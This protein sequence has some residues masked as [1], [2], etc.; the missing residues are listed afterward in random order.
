MYFKKLIILFFPI[1]LLSNDNLNVFDYYHES[2]CSVL[3]NTSNSIDDY[4]IEDN[5]ST[6]ST[7]YAEFSTL[8]AKES[9]SKLEKDIRFH[10]RLNLPKI[11]KNL[12]LYFEDESSDNLLYDGTALDNEQWK[13]KNYYLRLEFLKYVKDEFNVRVGA[14]V[15]FRESHLVPYYNIRSNYGLYSKNKL[16]VTLYNRFRHYSDGEIENNFE[17][18]SLYTITDDTL[19]MTFRNGLYYS[20]DESEETLSSSLSFIRLFNEKQ[21]MTLGVGAVSTLDSF[22]DYNLEY[23]Y[24]QSTFHHLFYKDWLYYEVSPSIL[25]RESNDFDISYRMLVKLGIYFKSK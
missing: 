1:F 14:G 20:S 5:L 7:T 10:L 6:S 2:L 15:R 11:Q 22:Q 24:L 16:D 17:V 25:K 19:F 3:V 4:F 9:H 13:N 21:Q 18:N 8:V 12:R 23:Y